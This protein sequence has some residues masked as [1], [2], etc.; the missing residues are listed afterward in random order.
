MNPPLTL[1]DILASNSRRT[2]A[3]VALLAPGRPPMSY[4]VLRQQTATTLAVLRHAGIGRTDRVAVVLPNGPELAAVSLAIA[5]GAV[6]APL[7]PAFGAASRGALISYTFA[8]ESMMRQPVTYIDR[9][10][11]GEPPS[12]LPVQTPD[13]FV[14]AINLAVAKALGIIVPPTL[15]ALA[16]QVIE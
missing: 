2:D 1:P 5:S 14:L 8:F 4:A 7:N 10:L 11:R 3:A 16:D 13:K 6:C 12:G 15:L 9:I